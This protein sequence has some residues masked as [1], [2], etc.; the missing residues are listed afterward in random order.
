MPLPSVTYTLTNGTTADATQV[1]QNF[2]DIINALTD[3]LKDLTISGLAVN[4]N[5]TLGNASSDSITFTG[6]ASSSLLPSS[7]GAY[8]LGSSS[9]LFR[10]IYATALM[11]VTSS[12]IGS[13]ILASVINTDNTDPGSH[14]Y[15]RASSG[16]ASGGDAWMQVD[17]STTYWAFGLDNSDSDA[18]KLT[19]GSALG[20]TD[21]LAMSTAGVLTLTGSLVTTSTARF[22]SASAVSS[23]L[24]TGK[25][26]IT[27]NA[28]TQT[29]W[30]DN[31]NSYDGAYSQNASG[32]VLMRNIRQVTNSQTDTGRY[33]SAYFQNRFVVPSTMTLTNSAGYSTALQID[34]V[35]LSGGGSLA[36]TNLYK[37]NIIA[38]AGA[39]GTRKVGVVI[40]SQ[41]GATNNAAISDGTAFTGDWWLYQ[42]TSTSASQ[43]NGSL[44]IGTAA[45]ATTATD[46]FVYLPSCAGAP[47]GVPTSRTGTVATVYDTS[48]NKLYVY[49]GAWKSVTLA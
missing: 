28:A 27:T 9:F 4:G 32:S 41:S 29:A 38:D 13:S 6:R 17:N 3:G 34:A 37:I 39:H 48:N 21:Y 19:L 2:T 35:N 23:E 33:F 30:F 47:T 49:N 20:G 43:L 44:V 42:G 11:T 1:A 26:T 7:T 31:T 14:A 12:A 15:F 10:N 18:W 5:T 46:G 36:I 22:G 45:L 24:I 16:G 8:D 40:N 25:Q